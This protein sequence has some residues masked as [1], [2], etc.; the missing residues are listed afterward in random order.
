[1]KLS[2]PN[3]ARIINTARVLSSLRKTG[4][5]SK[6]DLARTLELNKVSTGEIVDSLLE[7]GL[8]KEAGKL[9]SVNGR[10]ATALELVG[11]SAFV[12][13][14]HFG[15]RFTET[16]LC[17]LDGNI[18]KMERL[19]SDFSESEEAFFAL[20]IKSCLRN[21]KLV[22]DEQIA[23]VGLSSDIDFINDG[24]AESLKKALEQFLKKE[25]VLEETSIALIAAEKAENERM[26]DKEN[27]LYLNWGDT[28]E[29]SIYSK[30]SVA[31]TSAE[32]GHIM[33]SNKGDLESFCSIYAVCGSHEAHFKDIWDKVGT[34]QLS[35]MAKALRT[36]SKVTGSS[37]VIIGGE[38]ATIEERC[39]QELR[40]ACPGMKIEASVLGEKALLRGASELALDR[41][42]FMGSLLDGVKDWI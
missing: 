11:D 19:P 25:V 37:S 26:R 39:L 31:G 20:V 9:D 28:V 33:V 40:D 23:G 8:V 3:S 38:G 7:R 6:A 18:V 24:K 17:S 12:L 22:K 36:A 1:M 27:L 4:G 32:F 30:G 2:Q 10:K 16:A 29:L 42:F 14:V 41:F 13:S 35:M 5:L 15:L 34:E 21:A